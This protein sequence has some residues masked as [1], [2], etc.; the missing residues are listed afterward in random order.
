[1]KNPVNSSSSATG[2]TLLHCSCNGVDGIPVLAFWKLTTISSIVARIAN[3]RKWKHETRMRGA[4]ACEM[5]ISYHHPRD[6]HLT[7][8]S[9]VWNL[10]NQT[11]FAPEWCDFVRQMTSFDRCVGCRWLIFGW[12]FNTNQSRRWNICV[13]DVRNILRPGKTLARTRDTEAKIQAY[14]QWLH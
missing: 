9:A 7:R 1:M 11:I 2:S 4:V 5:W 10:Q 13:H 8:N 3:N 6:Q 14:W 12:E